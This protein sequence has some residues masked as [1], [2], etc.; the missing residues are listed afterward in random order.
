VSLAPPWRHVGLG[1]LAVGLLASPAVEAPEGWPVALA[2]ASAA[3]AGVLLARRRAGGAG[4][5]PPARLAICGLVLLAGLGIGNARLAAS[6][7]AALGAGERGLEPGV[8]ARITGFVATTPRPLG[9]MTRFAVDTAGGR[10]G[11]AAARPLAGLRLGARVEAVGTVEAPDDW[12]AGFARRDGWALEMRA[13]SSHGVEILSGGRSGLTGFLDRAR[14]R[15]EDGLTAGLDPPE[16]ALARG[17]V[18]GQDEAIDPLV[19]ESFRRS[20]LAHLLAVSGQNVML[21]ALLAGVLLAAIGIEPR[22]RLTVVVLAIAAYV[23][24]AG[25]GPSIQRAGVMGAAAI[26]AG[27]AGRGADRA[28]IV[29]LAVAVTLALNPLSAGD[30]GWQLSFAAVIGIALWAGRIARLLER[31][32]AGGERPSRL[33]LR[34]ARPLAEAFA[35]TTAATLATAPLIA[36]HFGTVSLASLPANLAVVPVIAP[37]MWA[38]MLA[39]GLGQVP[40][41]PAEPVTALLDPLL[42]YVA[43][44][45]GVFG[46][47]SWSSLALPEPGATTVAAIYVALLATMPALLGA[48]ERRRGASLARPLRLALT[49]AALTALLLVATGGGGSGAGQGPAPGTLRITAVDVGQGDAVLLEQ[50]SRP[51]A[52]VDAGPPG[53]GIAGS[54]RS[55]GVDR[56]GALFLTHDDLDHTGGAP[57]L[58]RSLRVDRVLIG[59]P[60]PEATSAARAAGV[61]VEEVAEGSEVRIGRLRLFVLSPRPQSPGGV[62]SAEDDNARSLVLMARWGP[63]SALLTADA[64]AE[65]TGLAPGPFDVLKL[66]HHGSADA[67]LERMLETSAPRIALIGVGAGN[68]YGH[69]DPATMATLAEHGV[70]AL[71]TDIDGNA[72][73]ELGAAGLRAFAEHGL[74]AARPG[75]SAGP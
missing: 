71:R 65:A 12:L 28:W 9:G 11:V 4:V 72:G 64:E 16:A 69:P 33:R 73:V 44:V 51:A 68:S 31:P 45:A 67:G 1:C 47:P 50:A 15:A 3:L 70:C 17:F 53:A 62:Q 63:W 29:L 34:L 37:A 6:A 5:P 61:P 57:E 46:R 66:A 20:G 25:A 19:R 36:H 40:L 38:G 39:A 14:S 32:L 30:V 22:L 58:L 43:W 74:D 26:L 23:P 41:L 27:L 42:R 52:L 49:V 48:L 7:A 2:V 55:L 35:L 18:L 75:C 13:R 60:V 21:L 8:T 24:I 54:L 59:D 10:I 56:V